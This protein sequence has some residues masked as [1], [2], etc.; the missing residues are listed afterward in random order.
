MMTSSSSQQQQ[1]NL[2]PSSL[3]LK[4]S[5]NLFKKSVKS[6]FTVDEILKDQKKAQTEG[7]S[8]FPIIISNVT[9]AEEKSES[10]KRKLEFEDEYE[11]TKCMKLT[12]PNQVKRLVSPEDNNN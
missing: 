11:L 9:P 7:K 6:S 1:Q 5:G 10:F 12:Q 3:D 8:D 4:P 2:L